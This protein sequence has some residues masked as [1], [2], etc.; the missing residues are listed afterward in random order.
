[1]AIRQETQCPARWPGLVALASL[2]LLAASQERNCSHSR[3]CGLVAASETDSPA[4]LPNT[5]VSALSVPV[6]ITSFSSLASLVIILT[7]LKT[8]YT[9]LSSLSTAAIYLLW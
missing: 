3:G 7:T 1:M 8:N 6:L 5:S 9:V 4:C 2:V